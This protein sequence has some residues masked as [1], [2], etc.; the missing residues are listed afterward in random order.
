MKANERLMLMMDM[1]DNPGRYTEQDFKEM[2]NDEDCR[3]CYDTLLSLKNACERNNQRMT[4]V[5]V[6]RE[7]EKFDL[8]HHVQDTAAGTYSAF[9]HSTFL[10]RFTVAAS[11]A[12]MIS[13]SYAAIRLMEKGGVKEGKSVETVENVTHGGSYGRAAASASEAV[14]DS[15]AEKNIRMYDNTELETILA[16]VS[17]AYGVKIGYANDAVRHLR[18][19]FQ[20]NPQESLEAVIGELNAFDRVNI[21]I[22]GDEITVE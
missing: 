12:L 21:K 16:E 5:D 18:L 7:W 15:I 19:F 4:A 9:R 2:L 3:K 20:W 10:R 17:K 6:R 8:S 11:V 22:E 14:S 1:L 13:I